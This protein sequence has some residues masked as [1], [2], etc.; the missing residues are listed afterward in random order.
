M[1][2]KG[3]EGFDKAKKEYLN[4]IK[5]VLM[6][7]K[8]GKHENEGFHGKRKGKDEVS[9]GRRGKGKWCLQ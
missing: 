4:I 3:F 2:F 8:G 6:K 9:F 1:I 5:G 7:G